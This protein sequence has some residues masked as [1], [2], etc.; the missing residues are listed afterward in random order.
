VST[1]AGVAA[2]WA[3]AVA[4]GGTGGDWGAVRR[5]DL[6]IFVLLLGG[7]AVSVEATRRQGEP[8]GVFA[9][10]LLSAWWLPI[11]FLLPPGYA[12]LAP[13]PV[14]ALIQLRV[15]RSLLHRR[16]F[17]AAA[18]GLA[19]AVASVAFHSL[20]GGASAH[21]LITAGPK[22]AVVW[23]GYAIGCAVLAAIANAVL[24][25]IPVKATS[26]ENS[27]GELL[28]GTENHLPEVVELCTG[29]LI[30]LV[31]AL[32]PILALLVVIPLVFLQRGLM[33]R[34]LSAAAR[35]DSK[36]G[37]LNALTLEREANAEIG[38]AIR[39]SSPLALMLVDIDHFKTI[40]DRHGHLAGDKVLC[41]IANSMTTAL[42]EYD[43]LARFGGDEFALLLPQTDMDEALRTAHRLRRRLAE[44]AV[45]SGQD[46]IHTT[47]SIGVAGLTSMDEDVTDLLAA[48]DVALYRAKARGRDRVEVAAPEE[49]APV[50]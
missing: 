36:T 50:W 41:G 33:H 31:C 28:W 44:L 47:V 40:N 7:A 38:R 17:S 16:V 6:L 23:T 4:L 22:D 48:A 43:L 1:V 27:W 2:L 5:D 14:M 3:L 12:L 49:G 26:P 30:A 35:I 9:N 46:T 29:I 42:R 37:L 15:R 19:H 11:A 45:T 18:I 32:S 24:V 39:T 34:Q 21:E 13:L 10:D 25:A 8:A 20:T